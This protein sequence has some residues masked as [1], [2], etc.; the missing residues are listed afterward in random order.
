MSSEQGSIGG[1][2]SN[3]Q[4]SPESPNSMTL[5]CVHTEKRIHMHDNSY[6]I[7]QTSI[8]RGLCRISQ[9]K[10]TYE[11]FDK[12]IF[13]LDHSKKRARACEIDDD[14]CDSVKSIN[15]ETGVAGGILTTRTNRFHIP[16]NGIRNL[17]VMLFMDIDAPLPSFNGCAWAKIML[18]NYYLV[19]ALS[20]TLTA[21]YP[22]NLRTRVPTSTAVRAMAAWVLGGVACRPVP[23]PSLR[24]AG[25]SAAARRQS[26]ASRHATKQRSVQ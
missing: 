19:M 11:E 24:P 14:E 17:H 1:S 12:G 3:I 16:R 22:S 13:N 9:K 5:C 10:V 18:T 25:N 21:E 20:P 4:P 6:E 7:Q 15:D 8:Q 23:I 26:S 2:K